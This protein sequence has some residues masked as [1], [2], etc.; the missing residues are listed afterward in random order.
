MVMAKADSRSCFLRRA[1]A[2]GFGRVFAAVSS[3]ARFS[4]ATDLFAVVPF[5]L[6]RC[7]IGFATAGFVPAADLFDPAGSAVVAAAV[8]VVVADLFDLSAADLSVVAAACLG[9]VG[10]VVVSV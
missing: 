8:V 1:R 2:T 4:P 3:A 7:L 9:F 6:C 5:A 10:F